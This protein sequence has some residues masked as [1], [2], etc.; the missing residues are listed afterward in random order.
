M[1]PIVP[2][3][4]PA[5]HGSGGL[6]G[7]FLAADSGILCAYG[8]RVKHAHAAPTNPHREGCNVGKITSGLGQKGCPAW[9][10]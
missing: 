2:R 6:E 8:S 4:L 3:P 5:L 10:V 7:A 1:L 9:L